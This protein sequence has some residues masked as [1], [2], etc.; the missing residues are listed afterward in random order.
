MVDARH[1]SDEHDRGRD[2]HGMRYDIIQPLVHHGVY[3]ADLHHEDDRR[4]LS[5]T[6]DLHDKASSAA[7]SFLMTGPSSSLIFL[8]LN[9]FI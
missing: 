8:I 6:G 3:A 1:D 2:Q 9:T 4:Y 5:E 7:S